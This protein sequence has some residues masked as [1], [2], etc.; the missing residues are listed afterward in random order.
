MTA[1]A[2][3]TTATTTLVAMTHPS[4]IAMLVTK[5]RKAMGMGRTRPLKGRTVAIRAWTGPKKSGLE[6]TTMTMLDATFA[7]KK[8]T[9]KCGLYS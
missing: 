3:R 1:R 8:D 9:I 6:A 5:A 2:R 4:T 7:V